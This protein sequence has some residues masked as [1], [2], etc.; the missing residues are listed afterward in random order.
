MVNNRIGC[1]AGKTKIVDPNNFGGGTSSSN[2]SVPLED[3]NI[4]VKLSTYRKGR[5]VLTSEGENN[6]REST[7]TV[8]IN[9][10]EGSD[11]GGKKVLT[12]KYTDL[13]T[14]FDKGTINSETLGITNID[15]DFNS[16]YAPMVSISFIDTRGS[17]IFQNEELISANNTANKYSTFFQLPYPLFEL[18]IKGYYGRPVTYCLHMLKFNSKFNSKTGN[19]EITCN[20]IGYTYAMLSDMLVGYLKA[21]PFTKIGAEKFKK[22]NDKRVANGLEPL[23]T[24]V[25][26]MIKISKINEGFDKVASTS[27]NATSLNSITQGLD[28]LSEIEAS[29]S[30]LG[31][32]LDFN[33]SISETKDKYPFIVRLA[34]EATQAQKN[35]ISLYKTNIEK[36]I[37]DFNLLNLGV[38]LNLNDFKD[39]DT[40][41]PNKGFYVGVTKEAFDPSKTDLVN[42][43]VLKE[44][45]NS[46]SNFDEL[47]KQIFEYLNKNYVLAD[48]AAINIYNMNLLYEKISNARV[49]IE[50]NGKTAREDLAKELKDTVRQTLNFEPTVRNIIEIFTAAIEV[51]MET[52]HDVSISA[53]KEDN[54]ARNSQLEKKFG[55]DIVRTDMTAE[56]LNTKKFFAWPDYREKD[57][58]ISAYVDK[59]LGA[60]GVL[61]RPEDVN[62][63]AFIDDLLKAFIDA[64]KKSEEIQNNLDS[65]QTTWFS[66]NPLDS[67]V[68][69]SIEPYNRTEMLNTTDIARLMVIRAMT[70]L[71]YS[72]DSML[73]SDDEVIGVA[74]NEVELILKNI[75]DD[76][77]KQTLSL[78]NLDF[79]K[80][81][82]GTINGTER[83]VIDETTTIDGQNVE[84][85]YYYNYIYKNGQDSLKVLPITKNFDKANW[86]NGTITELKNLADE[87]NKFLT[88]YSQSYGSDNDDS[89]DKW[90]KSLDGGVYVKILTSAEYN[91]NKTLPPL[92][93]NLKNDNII[94]LQAL[95]EESL[96]AAKVKEAGFNVFGGPYGL[97][98]FSVMDFGQENLKGLPLRFVFY[99]ENRVGLGLTRKASFSTKGIKNPKLPYDLK[100]SGLIKF[101]GNLL[102]IQKT[103]NLDNLHIE[104]GKNRSL[105]NIFLNGDKD[106]ISYPYVS[107]PS[108]DIPKG[109]GDNVRYGLLDG[110]DYGSFSLFGSY[111]YY[112]QEDSKT[113][114]AN[115]ALINSS[116][117]S[118]ALLFLNTLPFVGNGFN[119]DADAFTTP[120]AIQYITHLF[121]VSSGFVHVPRLWCAYIGGLLWRKSTADPIID[122]ASNIVGG[123]SGQ[124][125]LIVWN[126]SKT[127]S[128][129]SIPTRN[130]Y[131]P[132]IW[133]GSTGSLDRP[134]P[135]MTAYDLINRLPQ[136]V[137]DEFKNVF[138]NFV[139]GTDGMISWDTIKNNLEIW[140]GNS[141]SFHNYLQNTKLN[142]DG[143]ENKTDFFDASKLS[144]LINKDKYSIITPLRTE[145]R[146]H[147]NSF[148]LELKDGYSNNLAVR[149]LLDALNEE[150]II[151]NTNYKI[152]R[153]PL[154]EKMGTSGDW[155]NKKNDGIYVPKSKLE[156]YL[157]T[158]I[159]KLK[160][161][162][163]S[164]SVT[165]VKKKYE[166]ELFGTA[167]EELIKLQLYRTCKN[168]NDKWLAGVTNDKIFFQCGNRN[169]VDSELAKKYTNSEIPSLI[170]SFRFVSRSFKDI[171]D[172]LYIN[173]IPINDFLIENQNTSSYD[174]ITSLLSSNN[175]E[176]IALPSF[177]NFKDDEQLESLFKPYGDYQE[178]LKDNTCGPSFV[179]V[180][181]GQKSIHLDYK[182]SDYPNDGFDLRCING[183]VDPN[184][185]D[186]FKINNEDYE[187]P[188]A[189]FVV[190]YGQQNQN[191]FKDINLDQSEFT[192]TDES[193]QI[194]EDISLKGSESNK[195]IAGQNLYNVYA[196]RSYTTEI[197][198]M[199]NAMIQ[200]MMYFQLDNIPM[201]HG[202]Y[203]ITRVKHNIK[204]NYMSTNFT[205][206]RIRHA[207]T[208]LIDALDLYM[209][210]IDTLD[211]SGAGTSSQ[212]NNQTTASSTTSS[213]NRSA[214][215]SIGCKAIKTTDID[216]IE[217]LKNV[218]KYLEGSYC[219]GGYNCGDNKNK[220]PRSGE[221]LWG[222]DRKNHDNGLDAAFWVKID[223]IKNTPKKWTSSYPK[224]N[225]IPENIFADYSAIIK[226]DFDR[227][228]KT[229]IKNDGLKTLILND[230]RL[231]FNMIYAVYNGA[232]FFKGFAKILESNYNNGITSP[233]ELLK[234]FV[235]ERIYG[236]KNAFRLGT[237]NNLNSSSAT[238]IANTGVDIEKL[239]GL[240]SLC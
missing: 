93:N 148:W 57:E 122:N 205:G 162:S 199:G 113:E 133:D 220:P 236:G 232:G 172:E 114:F 222:L 12:T 19:F 221:T 164:F 118:K 6:T 230:G 210:F 9:F 151:A 48:T 168:I 82:S 120:D 174:A 117:Y 138:F 208:K 211:T 22:Y 18:E 7:N 52:I 87:E 115:G 28:K 237:G 130:E 55:V 107:Q 21:I 116:K 94:K 85:F 209:S 40:I 192:E 141:N 92:Q 36:S 154:K 173:P 80:N 46:P 163:D 166:Q 99:S 170:D 61:E 44:K 81:V 110:L 183:D 178:A 226:K 34:N 8:T 136:Q 67:E 229:Y 160:E 123:G 14:V 191:L 41:G 224:P 142:S 196:V 4:S 203:M 95:S 215:K 132:V 159:N 157:N 145:K 108:L 155:I 58:K 126:V 29:I 2:I 121:D 223:S 1:Q 143:S 15:I 167:N 60:M 235:D 27:P 50:Q 181:I 200:P 43:N 13:T 100:S 90:V 165:N 231:L 193:L 37:N 64:A 149:T 53:E 146:V 31:I 137:L 128:F 171:G 75:K 106:S 88:N 177:I 189:A 24:L 194:Q 239:V 105:F 63:I 129:P 17:S 91:T 10:I 30:G 204:P 45:L 73:L 51:F 238:L 150:M 98:D 124:K 153:G 32:E 109:N 186:D 66:I 5:T 71:G 23:D 169:I 72:N 187:D 144:Q 11:V 69:T 127:E 102:N 198:M 161:S 206:V 68:F 214:K 225:D 147:E 77:L 54:D 74:L 213:A 62:E 175:F 47:K 33:S 26:L 218:I 101:S 201:F 219:S 76:K 86:G 139:N 119:M 39:I 216:F 38:S 83:K 234:L 184:V 182:T 84:P 97:Q 180:Y 152:W 240:S 103:E 79:L 112:K 202:A 188:V 207:Q 104:L 185:P 16:S 228:M 197:E 217:T 190:R 20:F 156:L 125:D 96:D 35:A 131:F 89:S 140:N 134:Y 135:D 59:Y 3:L 227:F 233:D 70:F 56:K 25:D 111:F 212:D 176:F 179:C 195:T 65:T 158:M 78:L 42:Q 49:T